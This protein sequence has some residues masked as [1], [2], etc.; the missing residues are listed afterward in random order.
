MI[1]TRIKGESYKEHLIFAIDYKDLYDEISEQKCVMDILS[2]V[3][4][5]K[6]LFSRFL[7]RDK[8]LD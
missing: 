8:H 3:T 2:S 1:I 5:D 7:E 4:G 6:K